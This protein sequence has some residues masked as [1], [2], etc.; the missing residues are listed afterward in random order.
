VKVLVSPSEMQVANT[1]EVI[2]VSTSLGSGVGLAAY[3][4]GANVGGILNFLLP[5]SAISRSR[6]QENPFL[7]ADTG[8]PA[9]F[10][11]MYQAGAGK[12]ILT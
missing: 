1:S 5:S 10:E 11:A 3:D 7:F 12:E 8:I 4:S 6:A 2:L 9:F